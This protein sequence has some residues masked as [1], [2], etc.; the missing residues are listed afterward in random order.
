[1]KI[2]LLVPGSGGTFYCQNCLRDYSL[3]RALRGAGHEAVMLPLYLPPF[4][5]EA[6]TSQ[7]APVFFG[8]ISVYLRHHVPLLRSAPAW[9]DRM[10]DA[11]WML[12]LAAGREG[13]TNAGQL[14][15]MAISMLE[16][17]RGFQKKEFDRLVKWLVMHE[18]PDVIHISN[19]LLI[20]LATE[21]R[22]AMDVGIV[23]SLQDEEPWVEAMGLPYSR[24]CWE[25]I[26]RH[27]RNVSQ[28]IATSG[29][30]AERMASRIGIAREKIDVLFP[31]VE[32]DN[33]D[34]Q[35]SFDPPTIGFLSRINEAQG[36]NLVAEAFIDLKREPALKDLRLRAS[37]GCTPAD[38]P[39]F[40]DVMKRLRNHGLQDSV[41]IVPRFTKPERRQFLG[42]V[43]VLSTPVP[44]GEAFGAQLLEAMECGVPVVQPRAGSYPEIIEATGGGVLYDAGTPGALAG[45]LRSLL[46]DP[47]RARGL[48]AT[49]RAAVRERYNMSRTAD[50][51]IGLYESVLR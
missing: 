4:G 43:S 20:A 39:F 19:A 17:R 24:A 9:L 32:T 44:G 47:S 26:G 46:V 28:F 1:M 8:G 5:D 50:A 30:Y 25:A 35:V 16:G 6:E 7:R 27:A 2:C 51:M 14:G 13:S 42:S 37:G 23:C 18:K 29:W 38:R 15:P 22:Q 21:I 11:P 33:S 12:K 45:A 49:G 10:V 48:G 3:V 31:G 41:E 36:F 40:K 34:G